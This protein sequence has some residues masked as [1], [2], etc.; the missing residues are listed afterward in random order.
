MSHRAFHIWINGVEKTNVKYC[1]TSATVSGGNAVFYV[2]DN[3][4]AGGN[5]IFSNIYI[6]SMRL[7]ISDNANSYTF[8]TPTVASDKKSITVPVSKLANVLVGIIQINSAANGTVV[9]ISVLGD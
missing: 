2:T 6:E 1:A 7:S 4:S 9:N 3:N 5:P 8:G